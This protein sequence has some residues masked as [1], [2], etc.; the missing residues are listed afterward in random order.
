MG[1]GGR[2]SSSFRRAGFSGRQYT[3]NARYSTFWENKARFSTEPPPGAEKPKFSERFRKWFRTKLDDRPTL[4]FLVTTAAEHPVPPL[5]GILCM[6][7]LHYRGRARQEHVYHIGDKVVESHTTE[8][9]IHSWVF[10]LVKR[11]PLRLLSSIWGSIAHTELPVFMREAVYGTYARVFGCDLDEMRDPIESYPHLAAFFARKLKDGSR[12]LA[13]SDVV[14][15]V[16]G[17]VLHYGEIKSNSME[18]VK[19]VWYSLPALLGRGKPIANLEK[20]Q[21][22]GS[23]LYHMIIYL[24]PGD[25]HGIHSPADWQITSRRH[26]PGYLFPVA[27]RVANTLKG[28]FSLNERVALTG[29]WK[30]GFFSI[31]AVGATNVGSIVT[32]FDDLKTNQRRTKGDDCMERIYNN[33]DGITAVRGSEI[34][35]FHMGSTVVLV[36]ESPKFKFS[37]KPGETLRLGQ[38]LGAYVPEEAAKTPRSKDKVVEE[39]IRLVPTSS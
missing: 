33:G 9:A 6:C 8:K 24:A 7:Y 19:G 2:F 36:F 39:L 3:R 13:L 34:A 25:Y 21:K 27:P 5:L 38:S 10:E 1:F 22:S 4:K 14:S 12:T 17:T 29:Q 23:K 11:L 16:D 15:P 37:V 30:H 26:L 35:F 18:Q 32:P 28:L 20:A 31:T